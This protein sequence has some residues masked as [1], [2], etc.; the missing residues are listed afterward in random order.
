MIFQR[1]NSNDTEEID[2]F[3]K[4]VP[5]EDPSK[6]EFIANR[7]IFVKESLLFDKAIPFL[8]KN[9]KGNKW[10]ATCYLAKK[11][12]LVLENLRSQGYRLFDALYNDL[13]AIKSVIEA[14]AR[15]HSCSILAEARLKQMGEVI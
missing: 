5:Y 11:D 13:S 7:G 2:L 12:L 15:F 8:T 6:A 3:V 4:S 9:Y 1:K 14:L 10:A